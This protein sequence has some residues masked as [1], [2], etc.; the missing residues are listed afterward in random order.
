MSALPGVYGGLDLCVSGVQPLRSV[1]IVFSYV[2]LCSDFHLPAC[3]KTFPIYKSK[4]TSVNAVVFPKARWPLHNTGGHDQ[5]DDMR[6]KPPNYLAVNNL[7][8]N[9]IIDVTYK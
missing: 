7:N 2:A 1:F 8:N 5:N 3:I 4:T 9:Q 6:K